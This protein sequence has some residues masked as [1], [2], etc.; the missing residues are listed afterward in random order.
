VGNLNGRGGSRATPVIP[1]TLLQPR[2]VLGTQ[3]LD[4]FLRRAARDHMLILPRLL[5]GDSG[6]TARSS[7]G[8]ARCPLRPERLAN[9]G[10]SQPA[11]ITSVEMPAP[12][13]RFASV[14]ALTDAQALGAV[15]G[16]VVSVSRER[17][18][19]LGASGSYH[20][21]LAL[22]LRSGEQ[23]RLMLKHIEFDA[24]FT[25]YRTGSMVSR[26]VA[27]VSEAA[28]NGV[29]EI[30]RCPYLGFAADDG[31]AA[32]LKEDVSAYLLPDVDEPID[33]AVEDLLLGALARLHARYWESELLDLP[34]LVSPAT[35][36]GLLG[37]QAG[38]DDEQR[39]SPHSLLRLVARGWET[40]FAFLP[41]RIV[42]MLTRPPDEL[43]QA[44]SGLPRTLLH[45]DT[46][47]ANFAFLPDGGVVA[48]DWA[49]MGFGPPTLDLGWYLA[50]NSGR[51]AR[52]KEGVIGRYRNY[53]ET[54]LGATF[55]DSQWAHL[56]SV[57]VL[58]GA[59]M[60]LWEKALSVAAGTPGAVEE[61]RWWEDQLL[62]RRD[63]G[64]LSP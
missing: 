53:L 19:G 36:F 10:V 11:A 20:E 13:L 56:V 39:A 34:W 26:E 57:G 37:P 60:S 28:L 61:W 1:E 64:E 62:G 21:R 46:K 31:R 63:A 30:F 32:L 23:R 35:F 47:V 51:L 15:A 2:A 44:C 29:W 38:A 17:L 16:A 27:L 5:F 50:V 54:A 52:P 41:D 40:A 14:D 58:H 4:G 33:V 43:A 25:V 9:D 18:S 8:R 55:D 48:F 6:Y 7:P 12:A 22:K 24:D 45:G 49:L 3:P 59:L 42:E